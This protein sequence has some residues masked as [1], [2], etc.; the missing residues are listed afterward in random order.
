M[1]WNFNVL[2]KLITLRQSN[3]QLRTGLWQWY[4]LTCIN[5][6]VQLL[7]GIGKIKKEIKE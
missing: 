6:I 2:H 7:F 1:Q 3:N 4:I 5:E